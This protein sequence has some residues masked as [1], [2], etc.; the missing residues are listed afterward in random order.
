MRVHPKNR[1][2]NSSIVAA[3]A[4]ARLVAI[5]RAVRNAH[6]NAVVY[7]KAL[8]LTLGGPISISDQTAFGYYGF[9]G[10]GGL[11]PFGHNRYCG[12]IRELSGKPVPGTKPTFKRVHKCFVPR[13]AYASLVVTY[14]AS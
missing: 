13:F 9:G 10:P 8:R 5:K 7:A 6:R 11:G 12:T 14:S 3:V 1:H 2:R 4:A